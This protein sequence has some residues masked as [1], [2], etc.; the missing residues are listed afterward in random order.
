MN[1]YLQEL[2]PKDLAVCPTWK[3]RKALNFSCIYVVG[4]FWPNRAGL[5]RLVADLEVSI[6]DEVIHKGGVLAVWS[7][8]NCLLLAYCLD[9]LF[10]SLHLE[11]KSRHHIIQLFFG[12][13]FC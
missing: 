9:N 5:T 4:R 10:A 7:I 11:E 12:G 1:L 3:I 8:R 6:R 2:V 13:W